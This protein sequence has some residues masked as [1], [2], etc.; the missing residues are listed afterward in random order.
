MSKKLL[1]FSASWTRKVTTEYRVRIALLDVGSG[2]AAGGVRNV[3]GCYCTSVE[4]D[5]PLVGRMQWSAMLRGR[6][7]RTRVIGASLFVLVVLLGINDEDAPKTCCQPTPPPS[8]G[9]GGAAFPGFDRPLS[10]DFDSRFALAVSLALESKELAQSLGAKHGDTRLF[11]PGIIGD[12]QLGCRHLLLCL[13]LLC[14][15]CLQ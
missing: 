5:D 14:L 10:S 4:R 12:F 8:P 2:S 7:R 15:R 1:S 6:L 9:D 11:A 13:L 3:A